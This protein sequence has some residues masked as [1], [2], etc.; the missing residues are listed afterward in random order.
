MGNVFSYV[1]GGKISG[2]SLSSTFPVFFVYQLMPI[3][4]TGLNRP[5]HQGPTPQKVPESTW[6]ISNL[7]TR[8]K[9]M[10]DLSLRGRV[11]K[12]GHH[13]VICR[14]ETKTWNATDLQLFCC[15][16]IT[17][18]FKFNRVYFVEEFNS[19]DWQL[20]EMV[21]FKNLTSGEKFHYLTSTFVE[22]LLTLYDWLQSNL[23]ISIE[24]LGSKVSDRVRKMRVFW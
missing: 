10:P 11:F 20:D 1:K 2:Q 7:A 23:E 15:F 22:F 4:W 6:Q 5:K 12:L 8:Q 9:N 18:L 16:L 19:Y 24:F 3:G 17:K 13:E 14:K 21:L